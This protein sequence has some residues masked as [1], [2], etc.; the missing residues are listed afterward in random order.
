MRVYKKKYAV[1]EAFPVDRGDTWTVTERGK[2]AEKWVVL[3]VRR[4]FFLAE[5][6]E[7]FGKGEAPRPQT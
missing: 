2:A 6:T 1:S 3:D 7:Y 4:G 5:I